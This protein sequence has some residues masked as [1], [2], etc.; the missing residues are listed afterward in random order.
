MCQ[1][2]SLWANISR[3]CSSSSIS[4][5][6]TLAFVTSACGS[7]VPEDVLEI[8][9]A[10]DAGDTPRLKGLL[11]GGA[12]PTP[13]GSPL[14]P[15]HAAITHFH[16]GQLVCDSAAVKLLLDHGADPSFVDQWSGFSALEDALAMG[17]I[18]CAA[19]LKDGGA[20]VNR[21]G[22]SGQSYLQFAVKGALRT[23]D[24]RILK[25]VLSWG[26]GPNVLSDGR[27]FTA[28]HEAVWALPTQAETAEAV[29]AELLSSGADPC[30]ANSDGNTPLDV[31]ANLGRAASIQ[32]RLSDAMNGCARD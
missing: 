13:E 2:R 31:A 30:I 8:I 10:I 29:I 3:A 25:L 12:V 22:N 24:T 26:V 28:L 1:H 16:N 23:G 20:D 19:L 27:M 14:S 11:E 15:F 21:H 18:A 6:I 17:D 9:R 32:A 7:Q 5:V 4:V